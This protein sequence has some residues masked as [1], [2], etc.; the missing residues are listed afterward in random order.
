RKVT[1]N[2]SESGYG[3]L[4]GWVQIGSQQHTVFSTRFHPLFEPGTPQYD[5]SQ[6]P[7]NQAG[8]TQGIDLVKAVPS[9]TPVIFAGDFNANWSK[10][11][12]RAFHDQS[13]L[14]DAFE[15]MPFVGENLADR[16]DYVFYRGPYTLAR[17]AVGGNGYP[18]PKSDHGFLFVELNRTQTPM[19]SVPSVVGKT[20]T[21][22]K[23]ALQ[24]A[25][26]TVSQVTVYDCV[27]PWVVEDQSPTGGAQAAAGSQVKIYVAAYKA[28][29]CTS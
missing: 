12:S 29:A 9:S 22:A 3:T 24:A 5:P 11:W 19:A 14:I 21:D 15:K 23:A 8:H 1:Y 27:G 7:E 2:G 17:T 6:D 20:A 25:G 18:D 4:Q 13:G 10:W 16:K 28:T 26:Y